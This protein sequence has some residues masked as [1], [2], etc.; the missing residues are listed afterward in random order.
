MST[1][2][3]EPSRFETELLEAL[4]RE[5]ARF[6]RGEMKTR[7]T[8]WSRVSFLLGKERGATRPAPEHGLFNL[9]DEFRSRFHRAV[10]R[11]VSAGLIRRRSIRPTEPHPIYIPGYHRHNVKNK[12][13]FLSDAGKAWLQERD[14]AIDWSRPCTWELASCQNPPLSVTIGARMQPGPGRSGPRSRND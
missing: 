3:N 8:L 12:D 2:R 4:G 5:Q 1:P 13:I 6:E 7:G 11:L 14:Y 9:S 10:S